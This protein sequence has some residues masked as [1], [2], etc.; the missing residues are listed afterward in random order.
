MIGSIFV[1]KG[2]LD[3]TVQVW[4]TDRTEMRKDIAELKGTL[5]NSASAQAA[6]NLQILERIHQNELAI[7]RLLPKRRSKN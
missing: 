3:K 1:W 7:E 6:H 2:R 4:E 5:N